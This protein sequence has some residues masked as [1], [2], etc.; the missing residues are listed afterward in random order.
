MSSLNLGCIGRITAIHRQVVRG[1]ISER[2]A[3]I[4]AG[5]N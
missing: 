3:S 4:W 5:E 2:K 1:P